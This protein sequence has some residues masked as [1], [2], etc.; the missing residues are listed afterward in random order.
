MD[1]NEHS[2]CASCAARDELEDIAEELMSQAQ[3]AI[4]D[5]L[6]RVQYASRLRTLAD[7]LSDEQAID[8]ARQ[9]REQSSQSLEHIVLTGTGGDA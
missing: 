7:V 3:D 4:N 9:F 8:L 2:G 6:E 1:D 5:A